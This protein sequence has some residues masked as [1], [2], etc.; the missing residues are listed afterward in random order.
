MRG[1][2]S[3]GVKETTQSDPLHFSFARGRCEPC[4]KQRSPK[5]P[6]DKTSPDLTGRLGLQDSPLFF[7]F[8]FTGTQE[9]DGEGM[10]QRDDEKKEERER[11]TRERD[12]KKETKEEIKTLT[13]EN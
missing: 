10:S 1:Q 4:E 2:R 11:R 6:G 8:V 9:L 5:P 12:K 3:T 7:F 13:E